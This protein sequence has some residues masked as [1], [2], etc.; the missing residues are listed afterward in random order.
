MKYE[1]GKGAEFNE[2]SGTALVAEKLMKS[3]N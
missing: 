3:L 1:M 2:K